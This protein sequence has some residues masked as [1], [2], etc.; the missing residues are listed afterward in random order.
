MSECFESGL[1]V[2]RAGEA[3]G[4]RQIARHHRAG[5]QEA[6]SKNQNRHSL[7]QKRLFHDVVSVSFFCGLLLAPR[8]SN[9]RKAPP[10]L[11]ALASD[12]RQ[13]EHS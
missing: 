10:I 6:E 7:F 1:P 4:H 11:A 2:F 3:T 8:N 5:T 13:L 9:I 12:F